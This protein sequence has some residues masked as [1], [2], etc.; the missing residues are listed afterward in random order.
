MPTDSIKNIERAFTG[1]VPVVSLN[2]E[3]PINQVVEIINYKDIFEK[4]KP[5]G[6]INSNL[7]I[8]LETLQLISYLPGIFKPNKLPDYD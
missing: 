2:N 3:S 4:L 8:A 6:A 5:V 1:R 7:S